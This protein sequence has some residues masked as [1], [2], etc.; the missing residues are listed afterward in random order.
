MILAIKSNPRR[1]SLDGGVLT[2][3]SASGATMAGQK[4]RRKMKAPTAVYLASRKRG[5]TAAEIY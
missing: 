2:N 1:I 3:P 5:I 4:N